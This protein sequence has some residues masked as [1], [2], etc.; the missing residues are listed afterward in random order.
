MAQHR[1]VFDFRI[2]FTNGGSIRGEG[3]RLDVPR[4]DLA[5]DEV[6]TMLVRH[7]GLLMVA[8]VELRGLQFVAEPHKGSRGVGQVPMPTRGLID[9]SHPISDGMVTYPGLPGPEISDHLTRET[10]ETNYGP[11]ITFQIGRISMVA[12]TGTY[13]DA[14]FH[15]FADGADLAQIDLDRHVDLDGVVVRLTDHDRRGIERDEIAAHD[16]AGRAVLLHTGWDRYWRTEGYGVHAPYLM[17][18]A[19]AWLVEQRAGL[20]GIDSVNI[21]D[22]GDKARPAHTGL[23]AAGVP[24]VEHLCRLDQLPT[25]GFRFHAAPPAVEGFGTFTVRA[26]AVL[27]T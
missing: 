2:T 1:A 12:N 11:G 23:L 14:P 5:A 20:V 6:G 18:S 21:D 4:P 17:A 7:L 9:L 26:Y 15:R 8:E 19:V 3:F 13:V 25:S 24:I 10:A 16:V 22:M 27:G